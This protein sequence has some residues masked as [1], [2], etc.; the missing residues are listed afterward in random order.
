MK[1]EVIIM[2][3]TGVLSTISIA[4]TYAAAVGGLYVALTGLDK[5][6]NKGS[7]SK[8]AKLAFE[9]GL[10][11][12]EIQELMRYDMGIQHVVKPFLTEVAMYVVVRVKE[13]GQYKMRYIGSRSF[14]KEEAESLVS[15]I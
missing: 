5:R 3:G 14:T 10:E 4:I 11:E 7:L 2:L 15:E 8:A 9:N 12:G 1:K 6:F 13:D